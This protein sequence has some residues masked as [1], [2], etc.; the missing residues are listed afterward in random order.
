MKTNFQEV[1]KSPEALAEFILKQYGYR[2]V[3]EDEYYFNLLQWLNWE[4][5]D[6]NAVNEKSSWEL[7]SK[8]L[9]NFCRNESMCEDSK[10]FMIGCSRFNGNELWQ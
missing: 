4:V 1:T 5:E 3:K 6:D 9:C 2:Q 7:P 10:N 8:S